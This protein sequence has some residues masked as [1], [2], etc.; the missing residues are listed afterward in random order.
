MGDNLNRT[1]R[2]EG[3]DLSPRPLLPRLAILVRGDVDRAGL[4]VLKPILVAQKDRVDPI[5]QTR[6]GIR[7]VAAPDR[8]GG[9]REVFHGRLS[10]EFDLILVSTE[11]LQRKTKLIGEVV[12]RL[13]DFRL[14]G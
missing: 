6:A 4:T 5:T 1:L 9:Y 11:V 14:L 8:H 7:E 3:Y 12:N 10:G 13:K 2:E